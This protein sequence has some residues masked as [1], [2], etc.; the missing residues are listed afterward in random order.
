MF[1]AIC[2]C[3]FLRTKQLN[4]KIYTVGANQWEEPIVSRLWLEQNNGN[5]CFKCRLSIV[6][7][8]LSDMSIC[9]GKFTSCRWSSPL[10]RGRMYGEDDRGE[11]LRS[12]QFCL[13]IEVNMEKPR[14]DSTEITYRFWPFFIK[15]V[16]I[17]KNFFLP[18]NQKS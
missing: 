17:N 18:T 7:L 11:S 10:K 3:A 12:L 6:D 16:K 13:R 4:K 9:P 2:Y 8:N 1:V 15:L 14:K 5:S